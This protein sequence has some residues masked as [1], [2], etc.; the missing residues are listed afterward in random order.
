M[1]M[2]LEA[3]RAHAGLAVWPGGEQALAN[4]L[5]LLDLARRF[6]AA[7]ATSFRAWVDR[8]AADEERGDAGEAPAV[9][10]GA[11]GVRIMSVHRAKGLE[12]AVVILCDPTG[13][14]AP[15]NPSRHVETDRKLWAMP[16]AGCAPAELIEHGPEIIARDRAETVRLAYVAATRAR[17]LLVAPLVTDEPPESWLTPLQPAFEPRSDDRSKRQQGPGC[18]PFG[19]S[20]VVL[21][22]PDDQLRFSIPAAPGLHAPRLGAHALVIWD[23]RELQLDQE[24]EAGLRREALLEQSGPAGDSGQRAHDEWAARRAAALERGARPALQIATATALALQAEESGAAPA[25]VALESVEARDARRPHGKR[26]GTLVHAV[27]AACAL[28]ADEAA[29]AKVAALQGRL[30]G[31]PGDEVSAAVRAVA[32]ALRHPLLQRAARSKDCRREAPLFLRQPDG[33]LVEGVADLVF[34]E[35]GSSGPRWMVIDFKTDGRPGARA[36]YAAQLALYAEAIS[37]ATG[38]PA[39]AALLAV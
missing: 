28:D 29:L 35:E 25:A 4:V 38:E 21:D 11:E 6:E 14:A 33:A 12:F 1:S 22:R 9:E 39:E 2:L 19:S 17:D 31:A 10:E 26:F 7:G 32:A 13:P 8:L 23:P 18:P 15:R 37:R 34:R 20:D 5:R 30:V 3:T 36:A 16:L 27:L 24:P